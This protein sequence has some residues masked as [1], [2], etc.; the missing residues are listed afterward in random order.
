MRD[1]PNCD[2][3]Y[4]YEEC[5]PSWG[6]GVCENIFNPDPCRNTAGCK[7]DD[8]QWRCVEGSIVNCSA[9]NTS[10]MCTLY[11]ECKWNSTNC[12]LSDCAS[13]CSA[14]NESN[15]CMKSPRDCWWDFG[16]TQCNPYMDPTCENG[17]CD[18]CQTVEDCY[19]NTLHPMNQFCG[20]WENLSVAPIS[21]GSGISSIEDLLQSSSEPHCRMNTTC[22]QDCFRCQTQVDCLA[23]NEIAFANRPGACGWDPQAWQPCYPQGFDCSTIDNQSQCDPNPDC[24]WNDGTQE[25]ENVGHTGGGPCDTNCTFCGDQWSCG[26]SPM[27]CGWDPQGSPPCVQS[28]CFTLGCTHCN[29]HDD[30]MKADGKYRNEGADGCTWWSVY[31]PGNDTTTESCKNRDCGT[32]CTLCYNELGCSSSGV[33]CEWDNPGQRCNFEMGGNVA[34]NTDCASCT[35]DGDCWGSFAGCK[36][37]W[38]QGQVVDVVLQD[39]EFTPNAVTIS[40]YDSI[41]FINN[42]SVDH[43]ATVLEQDL[44]PPD[45]FDLTLVPGESYIRD[46]YYEHNFTIYCSI[47][48][49]DVMNMTLVVEERNG[50]LC[51]PNDCKQDCG[52]CH[53][54][55]SCDKS[56]AGC[57][58]DMAYGNCVGQGWGMTCTDDCWS[59]DTQLK[60]NA[61]N[62]TMWT[63]QGQMSGCQWVFDFMDG[64]SACRPMG[65]EFNCDAMCEQCNETQCENAT[66]YMLPPESSGCKWFPYEMTPKNTQGACHPEGSGGTGSGCPQWDHTSKVE[67]ESHTGC[68]W[69]SVDQICDPDFSQ[70][71]CNERCDL[72][73]KTDCEQA[74]QRCVWDLGYDATVDTPD[75]FCRDDYGGGFKYGGDCNG[76]CFDCFDNQSCTQSSSDCR[77]VKDVMSPMGYHCDPADMPICEEECFQCFSQE[78]CLASNNSL[79]AFKSTDYCVW[80]DDPNF[81]YC[82]PN[83]TMEIC[84]A[85]G[86]EDNNGLEGCKDPDCSMDPFCGQGM[87]KDCWIW[88]EMSGGNQ[89]ICECGEN[90]TLEQDGMCTEASQPSNGTGCAWHLVSKPPFF[91]ETEGLC[92]PKFEDMVFTG[93]GEEEPIFILHDPCF[94]DEPQWVNVEKNVLENKSWLDICDIGIRDMPDT[95]AFI[96]NLR[97]VDDLA[98]CNFLYENSQNESGKYYFLLD[99]DDN[100]S[101][102]CNINVNIAEYDRNPANFNFSENGFEYRLDYIVNAT[103]GSVVETRTV[104]QCVNGSWGVVQATISGKKDMACKHESI[105]FGISK[106]DLGNPTNNMHIV[107]FTAELSGGF[108]SPLVSMD[109]AYHAYY[110]PNTIDFTPPDCANNPTACG[111]GYDPNNGVMTFENCFPGTGDEDKDGKIN[112]EDEDCLTSI[113][114]SNG[115]TYNASTDKNAPKITSSKVETEQTMAVIKWT[116][117]EPATGVVQFYGRNASCEQSVQNVSQYN[118]VFF[119][120]DDYTSTHVVPLDAGNPDPGY[121]LNTALTPNTTYYYKL[122][123]CDQAELFSN[124]TN[125]SS[126]NCAVS[127]CLNFTTKVPCEGIT[128]QTVCVQQ[129]ICKWNVTLTPSCFK[130]IEFGFEW[131]SGT[132]DPTDP[133]GGVTFEMTIGNETT[134]ISAGT[135]AKTNET[136]CNVTLKF[137]NQ[138]TTLFGNKA[139]WTIE[140]QRCCVPKQTI[141]LTSALQVANATNESLFVGMNSGV[142][143]QI[144]Q[145][146]GCKKVYLH[147]PGF[148]QDCTNITIT[149]C[150]ESGQDCTDVSL[151]NA[152]MVFCNGSVSKWELPGSDPTL[153]STYTNEYGVDAYAPRILSGPTAEARGTTVGITT[154]SNEECNITVKYRDCDMSYYNSTYNEFLGYGLCAQFPE[155]ITQQGL[156]AINATLA[157]LHTTYLTNLTEDT[158]Y[159]YYVVATDQSNNQ[160]TLNNQ[161]VYYSVLSGGSELL[162]QET[163]IIGWN[164]ISLPLIAV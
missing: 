59:C 142:W 119:S 144:A 152:S 100:V 137:K 71:T 141:N 63:P 140:M 46:F 67:C 22:E 32:D 76:N 103:G 58:W 126:S 96:M 54:P 2:W 80:V 99:I 1:D 151:D 92:D 117:D 156:T 74:S 44:V 64:V 148:H 161:E 31:H 82:K 69:F 106:A 147:L 91:N 85:P 18:M 160:R 36:W 65:M 149:H 93:M 133:L 73:N 146:M 53:D 13:N 153:F 158:L 134:N 19:N 108:G 60:C 105:Y 41:K 122:R 24:N 56:Y 6:G 111:S 81:K 16:M 45:F 17:A 154:Y 5:N 52:A 124:S 114:C 102:G 94:A 48:G 116:T 21:A 150:N 131:Q 40:R 159:Y 84:F 138:M 42:D 77:W 57:F 109:R 61:S 3:D 127:K 112:C 95:T 98:L 113:F 162:E 47:H 4:G 89:E 9:Q 49:I 51:S 62:A 83:I 121:A 75:D 30:C 104:Y 115:T 25:C 68:K 129:G 70:M 136:G 128:N 143:Q 23:S 130:Q 38:N 50:S 101:S 97:D 145:I 26:S 37:D 33:G 8:P 15:A 27:G 28:K 66:P 72:C 11:G 135:K 55:G 79:K 155:N 163:L 88:D 34:C 29:G 120:N 86:D 43:T 78:D 164:L 123:S 12:V 7:W 35:I 139:P 125:S 90:G 118:D 10:A 20:W 14:C 132:E 87:D 110:T 157:Q 39:D 107:A